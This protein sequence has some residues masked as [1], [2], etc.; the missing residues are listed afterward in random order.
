VGCWAHVRR[1]FFELHVAAKSAL[2]EVALAH[3]GALYAVERA[4][5]DEGLDVKLATARRQTEA[6]PRLLALHA[7]LLAQR[8]Q[9]TDGTGT[10]KAMDYCLK[11]WPALMRYADDGR[12]P[13]D[14]NRIENQIRP[15]AIGRKNWLFSGS[16]A[17]GARAADIM[18]LIQ[19]AK[20]N[21]I[22][23]LAY[24]T[25]VLTRLPTHPNSRIEEL[26][27]TRWRPDGPT[28]Q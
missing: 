6:K 2:A 19:S 13:M 12:L 16:L 3:I 18:S 7:W 22:E 24:L 8:Q 10:A 23:P 5:H 26:L 28:R 11:R 9:V 1:K 4:I 25:N 27:P 14:N 15:W 17:A 21:G 20:M